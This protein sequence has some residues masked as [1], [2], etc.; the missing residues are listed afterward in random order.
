M[1]KFIRN[2]AM[3]IGGQKI[4]TD[5][6]IDVQYPFTEETIGTVPAGQSEH[7]K[8]AF[9]IASNFKSKLTRYE[10]QKILQKTAETLIKRKDEISDV[11]TL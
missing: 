6:T 11:I 7:A 10:R 3:R 2:E 9:D 4:K 1:T 5:E 8:K